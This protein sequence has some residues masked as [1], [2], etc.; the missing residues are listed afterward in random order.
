MSLTWLSGAVFMSTVGSAHER[1]GSDRGLAPLR[2]RS[3]PEAVLELVDRRVVR[4]SVGLGAADDPIVG[5]RRVD[6]LDAGRQRAAPAGRDDGVGCRAGAAGALAGHRVDVGPHVVERQNVVPAPGIRNR[7]DHRLPG[8]VEPGHR[9]ERV[10]V[11]PHDLAESRPADRSASAG[12]RSPGPGRASLRAGRWSSDGGSR[13][14][15]PANRCRGTP[16]P[17]SPAPPPASVPRRAGRRSSPAAASATTASTS[18]SDDPHLILLTASFRIPSS[19]G[20][21]RRRRPIPHR[22]WAE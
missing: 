8:H 9:I 14:S 19:T 10:E 7:D 3:H 21:D 16:R 20:R 6:P 15:R 12:T 2:E 5:R 17:R 18:F 13:P 4:R 11:R 22:G 1:R